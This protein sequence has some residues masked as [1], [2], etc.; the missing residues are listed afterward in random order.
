MKLKLTNRE[1]N[2][3]VILGISLV[4]AILYYAV[5]KP[6]L[7]MVSK[8]EQKAKDYRITIE[9]LKERT[10][11]DN[12]AYKEYNEL[13]NKTQAL[14]KPFYPGII[15]EKI[16]LLL[17]EK[18]KETNL[19]VKAIS[20][21]EPALAELQY[22]PVE[23]PKQTDELEALTEQLKNQMKNTTD[24]K[25]DTSTGQRN[26]LSIQKM[27]VIINF[28]GNYK[29]IYDFIKSIEQEN[30]SIVS[31]NLTIQ[32]NDSGLLAGTVSLDIYSIPKP[33]DQDNEYLNWN[34]NR[35]YGKENPFGGF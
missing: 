16:I 7:D 27:T 14:L 21:S 35:D 17:K 30:R 25:E 29:Q 33:F 23:Q 8:L 32:A 1:K 24:K 2:L 28:E 26:P 34:I 6:Q 13:Y 11:P 20:F 15:Q 9:R 3:L 4:A 18:T 12:P 10:N 19:T 5:I 22:K 31:S